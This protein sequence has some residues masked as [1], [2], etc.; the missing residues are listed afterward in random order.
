[1]SLEAGLD[2]HQSARLSFSNKRRIGLPDSLQSVSGIR[3]LDSRISAYGSDGI[4]VRFSPCTLGGL[5]VL[6][7]NQQ[8]I[9]LASG[10]AREIPKLEIKDV[11]MISVGEDG[12]TISVA[13]KQRVCLYDF[14]L[15][16]TSEA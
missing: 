14:S 8:V 13:A 5:A 12:R 11:K 1:M 3:K 6:T 10:P 2:E 4:S 7:W 9:D 16:A 15:D